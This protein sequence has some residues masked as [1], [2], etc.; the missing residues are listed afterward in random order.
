MAKYLSIDEVIKAHVS[1]LISKESDSNNI[2]ESLNKLADSIGDTTEHG[3]NIA[4]ALDRVLT[5]SLSGGGS[6]GSS[7]SSNIFGMKEIA[8]FTGD[9]VAIVD[10]GG[11][12]YHDYI[13]RLSNFNSIV[14]REDRREYM[15]WNADAVGFYEVNE[16][17]LNL[18]SIIN[19]T[20]FQ[21]EDSDGQIISY[22]STFGY[23]SN[24]GTIYIYYNDDN[25][26]M[27]YPNGNICF[28]LDG[29]NFS[30]FSER[31]YTIVFYKR[32]T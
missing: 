15:C 14:N 11:S 6:G 18:K 25:I 17:K 32:N 28:L 9:D 4:D 31:E 2:Q 13:I 8:R 26:K 24:I 12:S 20:P 16:D 1:K 10:E 29:R 5:A 21:D 27:N 22:S 30:D 23:S 3:L 19:L 7:D